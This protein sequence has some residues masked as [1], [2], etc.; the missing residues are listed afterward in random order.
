MLAGALLVWGLPA[1]AEREADSPAVKHVD[2][3]ACI[4]G[5]LAASTSH[6]EI[7]A[8]R[9]AVDPCLLNFSIADTPP[10]GSATRTVTLSNIGERDLSIEGLELESMLDGVSAGAEGDWLSF[11]EKPELPVVLPPGLK[12]VL[13]VDLRYN[14]TLGCPLY[15]RLVIRS[16]D[17]R[18]PVVFVVVQ[19]TDSVVALSLEPQ[20]VEMGGTRAGEVKKEDVRISNAGCLPIKLNSLGV[21]G[22]PAFSMELRGEAFPVGETARLDPGVIL[23][24]GGGFRVRIRFSPY[25]ERDYSG[26]LR[27]WTSWAGPP[28]FREVALRGRLVGPRLEVMPEPAELGP[29]LLGG[30]VVERA[31]ELHS[32]GPDAL[33]IYELRPTNQADEEDPEMMGLGVRASSSRFT[34]EVARGDEPEVP[35]SEDR[36]LVVPAGHVRRVLVRYTSA[37]KELL[38]ECSR[39]VLTE[40]GYLLL[41][42]NTFGRVAAIKLNAISVATFAPIAMI[43]L[44]GADELEVPARILLDG[45]HSRALEGEVAE[46]RWSLFPPEDD[47]VFFRPGTED[48]PAP[49]LV[50][51][52]E[53]TWRACLEVEDEAGRVSCESPCQE[54][55]AVA[56]PGLR[57]ELVWETPGDPDE[58]DHGPNA[59][60]DLDLHLVHPF[61]RGYDL[62]SDGA[63][64]GY[65]DR[66]FDCYPLNPEPEWGVTDPSVRDNPV[67]SRDDSD[68]GGPELIS[69][70][71]SV[72]GLRYTVGVH[73]WEDPKSPDFPKGFGPALATVRMWMGS[74]KIFA[75]DQV[76]L[77]EQDLW[78]VCTFEWPPMG[79]EAVEGNGPGGAK[80]I[81][82]YEIPVLPP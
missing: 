77:H 19:V 79:C 35:P 4:L 65:F 59:G 25:E 44:L 43:G 60:S 11:A 71:E 69:L 30:S 37:G 40:H 16:D 61:A 52:R 39:D 48:G 45:T 49:E 9:V 8:Q 80:V 53:G 70:L 18:H 42:S 15:G 68:G 57:I 74:L 75:S 56:V 27:V 28:D 12:Q 47:D 3:N 38:P 33:E 46:Y 10:G 5:A 24:P 34:V 73:Y 41:R 6:G 58:Q 26:V 14:R 7:G 13:Q 62:D 2:T 1:C 36:P 66:L 22:D 55:R 64:D 51:R 50:V 17:P 72:E 67:M 31:L 78:E 54:I 63:P 32:L 82:N 21:E 81:P 23:N 76:E 29:V 20:A